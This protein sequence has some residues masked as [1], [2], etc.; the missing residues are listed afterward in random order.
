MSRH[1]HCQFAICVPIKSDPAW[2]GMKVEEVERRLKALGNL[3]N[4]KLVE[5]L[6]HERP[7]DPPIIHFMSATVVWDGSMEKRWTGTRWARAYLVLDV[8]GDGSQDNMLE[9]MARWMIGRTNAN[10]IIASL[11]RRAGWLLLPVFES[12]CGIRSL[13]ELVRCLNR[14]TLR[15]RTHPFSSRIFRQALGLPFQG[16]PGL[17]VQ[18]IKQDIK[19]EGIA[20]KTVEA[21]RD[22][23]R[24]TAPR[25]YLKGA[26]EALAEDKTDFAVPKNDASVGDPARP[27]QNIFYAIFRLSFASWLVRIVE[28]AAV[29]A[30]AGLVVVVLGPT[31]DDMWNALGNL[32]ERLPVLLVLGLILA[33]G[34][35]STRVKTAWLP[36][37]ASAFWVALVGVAFGLWY[38]KPVRD[39]AVGVGIASVATWM[40]AIV[41]GLMTAALLAALAGYLGWR[42]RE[43]ETSD[44]PV[45]RDPDPALVQAIMARENQLRAPN[46]EG[47]VQNHLT[48]V[49]I[50]KPGFLRRWVMLRLGLHLVEL[51]VRSGSFARGFLSNIG[52]IHFAQWVRIPGKKLMFLS[53]YDGS[54]ES[55][56]ED[57][58]TKATSGLT[59]VWSNATDFPKTNWLAQDGAADGDRFKRWV[60]RQQ[61]PTLFWYSAYP[62]LT[63]EQIRLNAKIRYGLARAD[64]ESDAEEWLGYFTSSPRPARAIETHEIQRLVFDGMRNQRDGACLP[65]HFPQKAGLN[66]GN[67]W[68]ADALERVEFGDQKPEL[69][70]A[71]FVA[72]SW[73]GLE[74]LGLAGALTKGT[75]STAKLAAEFSPAFVFG[76]DHLT[77]HNPLG[78]LEECAP[79]RWGWG[80]PRNPT[81]DAVVLVYAKVGA[82]K[83]AFNQFL[84]SEMERIKHFGLE[85]ARAEPISFHQLPPKGEPMIE[86]FGYVDGISQPIIRGVDRSAKNVDPINQVNAGEFILGY[87]DGR[88][89]YPPT[90]QV[91]AACDKNGTLPSLPPDFSES[92]GDALK[93]LR[94]LGR[95]GSFLV[96]RQL[97]QDVAGFYAL[98]DGA[99]SRVQASLPHKF[100]SP[101]ECKDWIAAKMLGR[102]KNGSSLMRFPHKQPTPEE[103]SEMNAALIAT[104]KKQDKKDHGAS[105]AN[106][107]AGAKSKKEPPDV[108][109]NGFLYG[110]DDPQGLRC[111][112]GAHIR[113]A[114]PRDSSA[115]GD[116]VQLAITNRHRILRRGRIYTEGDKP[117]AGLFFMCLNADIERQ[118]EFVQQAWLSSHSFDGLRDETDPFVSRP[119]SD[120]CFTIPTPSGPIRIKGMQSYVKMCGGGYFFLPSKR[121]L[122]FLSTLRDVATAPMSVPAKP[123]V[124]VDDG[125]G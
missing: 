100:E 55:Y 32:A 86:P 3:A 118:F 59:I 97:E 87:Q 94:D 33:L 90:P 71:V 56:L 98:L 6:E 49:S 109:D 24:D 65:V 119:R 85:L 51:A 36:V 123:S 64:S 77:R 114:N 5:A 14:W 120:A 43:S 96:I 116:E 31:P 112:L 42:L 34:I 82:E 124:T 89:R 104:L 122:T 46:G 1:Q 25:D 75:A 81:V 111:P 45:D 18:R 99:V 11:V 9:G 72:L 58:I 92:K 7:G 50:V 37:V 70:S 15:P 38:S 47:V 84:R 48:A 83:N 27:K 30:I 74:K 8:T 93:Q 91:H 108:P 69:A 103:Q 44:N 35:S 22:S 29:L 40:L 57:F 102:W 110:R 68:L 60:R 41:V 76:M 62:S 54:W 115:P 39:V 4:G 63:A 52:T 26:R 78:D 53:N 88:D 20:R 125:T 101:E 23:K 106:D 13:S 107:S 66:A 105:S 67:A 95:N 121:A 21:M 73:R 17:S 80:G 61:I 12:A 28:F 16:T 113:R 2:L 117:K 10:R 79:D 19:I